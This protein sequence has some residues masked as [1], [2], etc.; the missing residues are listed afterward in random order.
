M[1]TAV[2][3]LYSN[4]SAETRIRIATFLV[5]VGK[6]QSGLVDC[7]I[8]ITTIIISSQHSVQHG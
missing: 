4:N 5:R 6:K 7:I 8:I 3:T 2:H 1:R